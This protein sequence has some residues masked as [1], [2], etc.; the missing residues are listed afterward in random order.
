MR[1]RSHSVLAAAILAGA[2]QQTDDTDELETQLGEHFAGLTVEDEAPMFGEEA[3]FE[4]LDERD[5]DPLYDPTGD[6][7]EVDAVNEADAIA[8]LATDEDTPDADRPLVWG[9]MV[10]WGRQHVDPEA[11]GATIWN[12]TLHTDCGVL[13]VRRLVAMEEGEGVA[14]P[15]PDQQTVSF[16]SATLPSFDGAVLVLGVRAGNAACIETGVLRFESEALDAPIE[17]P[18][19]DLDGLELRRELGDGTA[20]VMLAHRL[21]P[22]RGDLCVHG[23]MVGR[24]RRAIGEDGE[25]RRA[26]GRFHGRVLDEMGELRGHVRG[27][28]GV[29]RR[30]R[31]AGRQ[32]M[33]GKFIDRDGRFNGLLA[34]RWGDGHLGGGW[35]LT[36]RFLD[37]HGRYR[38]VYGDA[39]DREPDGGFFRARYASEG[40]LRRLDE[41]PLARDDDGAERGDLR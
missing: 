22:R 18:L 17:V 27:V 7:V 1:R 25:P 14:R 4:A 9:V 6:A 15:R 20:V 35:H 26:L 8:E 13:A 5:A 16:R 2:C 19:A 3:T 21:E 38:G 31:F 28:W 24:W 36:P 32:V 34:G 41:E 10:N 29:P 12:P 23:T 39:P 40:C 11:E 33:F 37:L 30:G